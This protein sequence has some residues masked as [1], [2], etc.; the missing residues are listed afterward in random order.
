MA[1]LG[2]ASVVIIGIAFVLVI[3]AMIV[4]E[5]IVWEK[6]DDDNYYI[7]RSTEF[8]I[9]V[10]GFKNS[11]SYADGCDDDTY[12]SSVQDDYCDVNGRGVV[13]IIFNVVSLIA[14]L[15]ALLAGVGISFGVQ[16]LSMFNKMVGISTVVVAGV[17]SILAVLIW[18]IGNPILDDDNDDELDLGASV[19]LALVGG[20]LYLVC[21]A[22]FV[23]G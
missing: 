16:A 6:N 11:E 14:G 15:I 1:V 22:G 5:L 7:Y 23:A 18:W 21:V 17:C 4:D 19:W 10:S 3:I 13:W 2:Q 8:E 12:P 9:E 20:V